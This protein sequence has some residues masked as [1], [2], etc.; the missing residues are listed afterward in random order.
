METKE[1]AFEVKIILGLES[2]CH[3]NQVAKIGLNGPVT[4]SVNV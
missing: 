4:N 1:F 3:D 2:T